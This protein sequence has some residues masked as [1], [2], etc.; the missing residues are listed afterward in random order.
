[1]WITRRPADEVASEVRAAGDRPLAGLT[2]GV[3]DNIDVAGLPTTCAHPGFARRP[4]RSA[5]VVE[6]L[7]AA[8]M[9]VAGKTNLDQFATGLVGTRSPYGVCGNAVVPGRISGGS[10]SGS[11]VAV[12]LG[13]VDAALGTDTAGSGR[14]PAA[15]NGIVGL[16]PTRGLLSNAGVMPASRS[17]DC[18]AVFAR[19]VSLAARILEAAAGFDAGD[20][21]SRPVPGGTPA[22][23]SGPFRIGVPIPDHLDGLDGPARRAWDAALGWLAGIGEVVEV[24]IGPYLEAGG[25]L[26]GS[27]LIAERWD[28]FG[29]FLTAHPEGADPSVAAI[30]AG[31]RTLEAH[32]FAHDLDALRRLGRAFGATMAGVDLV[33]VP[34]VAEAPTVG[35]V[36]ADPLG[37]N[38]RLGRFTNGCNLLD[39]CAAA[40]PAGLRED[41]VPFGTTLLAPAFG[42]A[43]VA[44]AAARLLG[45]PDPPLPSWAQVTSVVVAGAH[46]RGQPLAGQLLVRGGRFVRQTT[47]APRYRLHA[48][49]TEPP[50]PGLERVAD[51]GAPITVEVWSMPVD[52][53]GDL[54]RSVPPPLGFG[55]V[56]LADGTSH[57][58]F[59]VEHVA[60]DGTP[61]ITAAGGW[62]QWLAVRSPA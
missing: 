39:L 28:A 46:L 26:Y 24:D 48:L 55:T 13:Q 2:L 20:P 30:V 22:V 11:A 17:F 58:G 37:V 47:T 53:F 62:R 21:W 18:V 51:G 1:V 56:E 7:V 9:V 45:E 61:D 52:A 43:V 59:L 49:D 32:R 31:A 29:E 14:V 8:G 33:A 41:G 57:P 54:A 4:D 40:V 42:D 38:R 10:S 3:K 16:K 19:T 34:T 15:L 25:L 35:E 6:R 60:L 50:K 23:G 44:A 5:T 27:A 12:A 36:A